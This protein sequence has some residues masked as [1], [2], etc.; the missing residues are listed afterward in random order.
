MLTLVLTRTQQGG[1]LLYA[2]LLHLA[3]DESRVAPDLMPC[4]RPMRDRLRRERAR[5]VSNDVVRVEKRLTEQFVGCY[6]PKHPELQLS[7]GKSYNAKRVNA[8]CLRLAVETARAHP[9]Q[10]PK[11]VLVRFLARIEDD[12]GGQFANHDI[13]TRQY[14]ALVRGERRNA[15]LGMGLAGVPLDTEDAVTTF[16]YGHYDEKNVAWFNRWETFWMDAVGFLHLPDARYSPEF[17]LSGPPLFYVAGLVGAGAMLLRPGGTR[18]FHWAF[19]PVLGG[20]WFTVTLTGAVMPRYRFVLEPFWLLYFFAGVDGIA[21]LLP[22]RTRAF[23]PS[24]P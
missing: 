6:A 1:I 22:R 18:R 10:L 15:A 17:L 12:S 23:L 3:P 16:I 19:L 8:L 20:V 21:H 4:L 9:F 14:R 11:I 7:D 2:S 5:K 24:T 13:Q